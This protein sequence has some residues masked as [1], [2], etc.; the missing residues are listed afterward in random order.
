MHECR[1][2]EVFLAECLPF[3]L[4]LVKAQPAVSCP[5]LEQGNALEEL[6]SSNLKQGPP[7]ACKAA[8]HLLLFLYQQVCPAPC[9]HQKS[10]W[11]SICLDRS[12][13][14]VEPAS[15]VFD[16]CHSA[17]C[18]DADERK[19]VLLSCFLL[20]CQPAISSRA[21]ASVCLGTRHGA[22]EFS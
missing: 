17:L 13:A 10:C 6:F 2:G 19:Q 18:N 15:S 14:D 12:I 11:V 9:A 7:A 4:G 1:C 22:L 21:A 20:P 3:L 16:V 8:S 5:L